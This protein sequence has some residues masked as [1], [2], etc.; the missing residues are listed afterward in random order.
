MKTVMK[1]TAIEV[2]ERLKRMQLKKIE[3][4]RNLYNGDI[5]GRVK[6]NAN[7]TQAT[8]ETALGK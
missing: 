4:E 2:R 5:L 3:I 7:P 8:I 1:A 6:A